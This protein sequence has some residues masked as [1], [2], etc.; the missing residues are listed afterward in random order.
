MHSIG[1]LTGSVQALQIGLTSRIEDIRAD[2]RRL[3]EQ[4]NKRMDRIEDNLSKQITDQGEVLNKR[5]DGLEDNVGEKFKGLGTRV[6]SLE[7]EDKKIIE[8]VARLSAIGGGVGGAL[9][10]AAVEIIK[11]V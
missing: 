11:H 5:I 7:T 2:I 8:K 10:A 4:S 3:D 1:Q 6:T 9:A